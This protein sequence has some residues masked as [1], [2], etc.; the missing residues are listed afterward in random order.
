M[1]RR[2]QLKLLLINSLRISM[3]FLFYFILFLVILVNIYLKNK[4]LKQHNFDAIVVG[5]GISGG[6][7]AKELTENGLKVLL[8]ERGP[9]HDHIKDY[10]T[11]SL[12]PWETDYKGLTT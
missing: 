8:I 11:A 2:N 3:C 10:K 12:H 4:V 1:K 7:A 5:S 9:K 6:W